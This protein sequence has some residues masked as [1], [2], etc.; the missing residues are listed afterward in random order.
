MNN[1]IKVFGIAGW[2]GSGK[3]T[4]LSR[5]LP[6]LCAR[7]VV[8]VTVK[9]VH[10]SFDI[11]DKDHITCEWREAG[12][13]EVMYVSDKRWALLHELQNEVQPS[14]EELY[15]QFGPA[16]LLLIEGFKYH[17][18]TKLEIFRS[19]ISK[20]LLAKNDKWIIAIASD[21]GRPKQLPENSDVVILDL[22]D[23]SAV[24]EFIIIHNGLIEGN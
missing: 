13:S 24:A 22:N 7:G 17:N 12:A 14:V 19:N 8:V 1:D 4:L 16:D 11:F 18:H 15:K 2:S 10:H 6:E 5:L 3:T 23:I 21:S 20:P 9:Y